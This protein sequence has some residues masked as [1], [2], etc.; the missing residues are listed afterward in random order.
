MDKNLNFKPQETNSSSSIGATTL[1]GF[2][3]AT[4]NKLDRL[5][6]LLLAK[7]PKHKTFILYTEQHVRHVATSTKTSTP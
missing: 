4:R 7:I 3:P 5:Y 6:S 2:W 1:G